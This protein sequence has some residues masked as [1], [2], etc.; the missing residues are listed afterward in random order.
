[1]KKSIE[2]LSKNY[3]QTEKV[4]EILA[5]E[6]LKEKISRNSVVIGLIGNLGGG[7]TILTKGLAK[8]LGVKSR[9]T[10]PTFVLF[11]K[12]EIA[13]A[14]GY[15]LKLRNFYHFDVYRI[16]S[17]KEILTLGFK[18]IISSAENIV[19]IEWANKIQGLM[20]KNTIWIKFEFVDKNKRKIS[21][22]LH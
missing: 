15:I 6:L 1:M 12:M 20:P 22:R 8:G 10:S 17:A 4:G 7:K 11:K 5:E 2:I 16:K 3:L 9:I 19:I 18:K 21:I 13:D 14:N